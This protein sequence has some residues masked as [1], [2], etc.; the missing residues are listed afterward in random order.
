MKQKEGSVTP[1]PQLVTV[2]SHLTRQHCE[3]GE[4]SGPLPLWVRVTATNRAA[5]DAEDSP[6]L[7]PPLS[8]LVSWNSLDQG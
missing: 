8:F 2:T 3:Q 5:F 6:L 4:Q 1:T 7:V